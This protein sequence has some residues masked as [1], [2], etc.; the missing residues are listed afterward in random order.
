MQPMVRIWFVVKRGIIRRSGFNG[1]VGNQKE[2]KRGI[3]RL[4]MQF[5]FRDKEGLTLLRDI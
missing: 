1:G 2:E 3:N 4:S 5:G